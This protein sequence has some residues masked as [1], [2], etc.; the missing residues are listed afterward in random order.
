MSSS[1]TRRRSS[2][3]RRSA[4]SRASELD[5]EPTEAPGSAFETDA[6]RQRQH[7]KEQRRSHDE[8]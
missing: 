4:T 6:Y 1:R 2:P 5:A 8:G 3:T 7:E